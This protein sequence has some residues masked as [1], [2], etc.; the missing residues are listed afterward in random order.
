MPSVKVLVMVKGQKPPAGRWPCRELS[1]FF[2]G[3]AQRAEMGRTGVLHDPCFIFKNDTFLC[4]RKR[5]WKDIPQTARGRY[6]WAWETIFFITG[7][8]Q[9]HD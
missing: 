7:L 4:W 5:T 8:Y 3:A 6:L 2:L 1:Q 9:S